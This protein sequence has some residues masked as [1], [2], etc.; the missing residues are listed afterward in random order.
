MERIGV[1]KLEF[2]SWLNG[3][4]DFLFKLRLYSVAAVVMKSCGANSEGLDESDAIVQIAQRNMRN[5]SVRV[6][7]G[8]WRTKKDAKKTLAGQL[9]DE[10]GG[11][12]EG[13]LIPPR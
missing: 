3:Y 8:S 2:V 5:T 12:K 1:T 9:K 7:F 10:E 6:K 13:S 11:S 4:L